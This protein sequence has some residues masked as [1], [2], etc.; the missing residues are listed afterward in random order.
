MGRSRDDH[1]GDPPPANHG[2]A[3]L[4]AL[5]DGLPDGPTPPDG[6][7][8]RPAPARPA[9]GASERLV[10]RRERKGH[11]GRT[12][13]RV[14]GLHASGDARRDLARELKRGMG[15]G[16]R[17]EEDD[18]LVQGGEVERVAR[19]FEARGHRVVRGTQ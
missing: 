10:V 17:W 18:L 11:G 2:L 6:E 1:A 7:D 14:S 8:A 9:D 16:A 5:R 4:R 15:C 13:T 12:A 19:W 3:G